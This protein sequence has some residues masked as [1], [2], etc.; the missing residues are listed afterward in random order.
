[1]EELLDILKYILPSGVVFATAYFLFRQYLDSDNRKKLL[2]LKMNNQGLIAPIRL[3]AYER[4]ILFLERV[5]PGSLVL[6]VSAPGM[7]AFQFQTALIENIREEFEHNLSQQIYLTSTSW[8]LARNAKEEMIKL[9][10]IAASKLNDSAN[11]TD[12]G[13]VIFELSMQKEKLPVQ[14]AIAYIKSEVRQYF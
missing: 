6:R 2:E 4:V 8:E 7:S 10:N 1:M 12:L 9:V 14:A 13:S 11:A 3:Q 5:S